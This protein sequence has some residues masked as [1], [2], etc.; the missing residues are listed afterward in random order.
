MDMSRQA[1]ETGTQAGREDTGTKWCIHR[2]NCQSIYL[3]MMETENS[4]E[5]VGQKAWLKRNA[6]HSC[7]TFDLRA[8]QVRNNSEW[9]HKGG[10]SIGRVWLLLSR[11]M[12]FPQW[13][14]F[15]Q[16]Q[17][18]G[19]PESYNQ[20][21]DFDCRDGCFQPIF[22]QQWEGFDSWSIFLWGDRFKGKILAQT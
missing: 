11:F 2:T 8:G 18:C 22:W 3:S 6:C 4:T 13:R 14:V 19:F 15:L 20:W 12:W 21:I 7:K 16:H 9:N 17:E 1:G 10:L 5:E